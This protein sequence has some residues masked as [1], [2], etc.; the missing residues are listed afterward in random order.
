MKHKYHG[1]LPIQLQHNLMAAAETKRAD[2]LD[3]TIADVMNASP[4]SFHTAKTLDTRIFYHQPNYKSGNVPMAGYIV[5]L[6][7]TA[8]RI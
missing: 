2:L 7:P 1:M 6:P 3:N 8:S 4:K 5:P